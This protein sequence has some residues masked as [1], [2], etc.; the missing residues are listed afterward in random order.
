VTATRHLDLLGLLYIVSGGLAGVTALSLFFLGLGALVSGVTAGPPDVPTRVAGAVFLSI[1]VASALFGL[2]SAATG[3][4]L[5]SRQR[6]ARPAG[7]IIALVDLF[8]LPFG[9]ALGLYALWV[10]LRQQ[11]RETFGI[12]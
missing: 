8:I 6:W 2:L 9:T 7:L 4:A 3:A 10:L 5:R 11:T 1:A 12:V